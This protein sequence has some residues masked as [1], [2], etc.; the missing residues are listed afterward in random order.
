MSAVATM[1]KQHETPEAFCT[2]ISVKIDTDILPLAKAA[3]AL[4]KQSVQD[5]LSDIA[6]EEAA[7]VLERNPIK[8]KPPK[9]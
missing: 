8:R 6:N 7:K 4:R 2:Y 3:A 9:D 5:F 1:P